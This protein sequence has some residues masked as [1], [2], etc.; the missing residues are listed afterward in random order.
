MVSRSTDVAT[1]WP[2]DWSIISVVTTGNVEANRLCNDRTYRSG[3]NKYGEILIYNRDLTDTERAVVEAY[4]T[5]KWFASAGEPQPADG[6]VDVS[7]TA[8][9]SWES[10]KDAV[11]HDVYFGTS[12]DDVSNASRADPKGVLVSQGQ[13]DT[14]YVPSIRF[15]IDRTY[16]WRVDEIGAAPGNAIVKGSVWSF[17]A[18]AY[19]IPVRNVKA[20][21]SSSNGPTMGPEKTVDGSGLNSSDQHSTLDTDMWLSGRRQSAMDPV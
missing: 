16:Y 20:T 12:S 19:S 4:L 11:T 8:T 6:A 18:E 14:T 2:D 5:E 10:G 1:P 13:T 21:A 7:R 3:G 9:L 15:E 17:T